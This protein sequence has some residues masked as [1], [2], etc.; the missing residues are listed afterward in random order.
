MGEKTTQRR[1]NKAQLIFID[2][3]KKC[4]SSS[5]P[6]VSQLATFYRSHLPN[7]DTLC[8]A[9][10]GPRMEGQ[11]SGMPICNVSMQCQTLFPSHHM[12]TD[13]SL[14][15]VSRNDHSLLIKYFNLYLLDF[16][17]SW[18]LRQ[19]TV[20]ILYTCIYLYF[21]LASDVNFLTM[22]EMN[23]LKSH[24]RRLRRVWSR[25]QQD[26]RKWVS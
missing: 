12:H 25:H 2:K 20:Y 23:N 22:G 24:S 13:P 21:F 9:V 18:Q 17:E 8:A 14:I 3:G 16:T 6:W 11:R 15:H 7:V 4:V 19:N 5:H 10:L 26:R 1:R